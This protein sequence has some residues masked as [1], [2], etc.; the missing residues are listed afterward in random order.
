MPAAA[1][2]AGNSRA[3]PRG[4]RR[5]GE[6]TEAVAQWLPDDLGDPQL[7]HSPEA[8]QAVLGGLMLANQ[9][10][11]EV[12]ATLGEADFFLREHRVIYAA[13][14][15]LASAGEPLDALTSPRP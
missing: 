10:F 13:M 11:D 7:P 9:A 5:G 2:T 12:A 3:S 4:C 8:E 15:R 1:A 14:G 6:G